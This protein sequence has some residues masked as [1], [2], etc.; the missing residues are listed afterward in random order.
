MDATPATVGA[1]SRPRQMMTNNLHEAR[2]HHRVDESPTRPGPIPSRLGP[3]RVAQFVR[4]GPS[5]RRRINAADVGRARRRLM[6]VV[7]LVV[8]GD[9]K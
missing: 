9:G 1:R 3:S 5:P 4:P 6:T 2:Y 7:D 8:T